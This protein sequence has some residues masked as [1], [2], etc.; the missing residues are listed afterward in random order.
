MAR[1]INDLRQMQSLPL[2]LKIALTQSRIRQ[3]VN[4]YG[5]EGVYISFSGGK[6]S[7]VLCD[8]VD[9]MYPENTIPK[10]FVNTG[11]EYPELVSFVK[12]KTNVVIIRPEMNFKKVVENYGYPF[13]T[14]E[15]AEC[16]SGA[17]RYLNELLDRQTDSITFHT[18]IS[19]T[20]YADSECMRNP[21]RG[22]ATPS[23]ENSEE[24]ASLLRRRRDSKSGGANYRT[25][26]MLGMLTRKN[27]ILPAENIP[28]KDRSAFAQQKW[29]FFLDPGAPK[30]SQ[31]CCSVMKKNPSHRYA[32]QT[33]RKVMTAE[34]ATESRLR[35]QVWLKH[36]CN[37]FDSK[38]PKSQ[39]MAFWT[40]QDV[41]RYIKDNDITIASVYGDVVADTSEDEVAL[42]Q[43]HISDLYGGDVKLKTTGCK[44]TGCMFCGYGC[45]L[46][47][48]GEGRFLR[49]KETHPKIYEWIMK[50]TDQGGLGYKEVIDWI[51][52]HGNLHIEY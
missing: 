38:E 22:G 31:R 10:V 44:R 52:E 1:T 11:L 16:I 48:P 17:Q 40:E 49:L 19:M 39:P 15:A 46:E 3:W 28:N 29:K 33:G 27:E 12:Q 51:N 45:H 9:K 41:L 32:K 26:R 47:A 6:D 34:M 2:S 37:G 18:S 23:I 14:K 4:E 42:G 7:T 43:M 24:L 35:T 8:I 20:S 50:P 25:A 5:E 36:G 13:P 21:S 30:V